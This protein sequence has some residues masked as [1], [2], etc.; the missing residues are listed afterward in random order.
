MG[1]NYKLIEVTKEVLRQHGQN[2]KKVKKLTKT[3][4]RYL[5]L[6]KLTVNDTSE[7]KRQFDFYKA[8]SELI[9]NS[10]AVGHSNE[11]PPS[12]ISTSTV[13]GVNAVQSMTRSVPSGQVLGSKI[14]TQQPKLTQSQVKALPTPEIVLKLANGVWDRDMKE[15]EQ[16]S[17]T[18]LIKVS[19]KDIL[20]IPEERPRLDQNK[21]LI[22][23]APRREE[24]RI[25]LV[26]NQIKSIFPRNNY[27]SHKTPTSK[28]PRSIKKSLNTPKLVQRKPP[29]RHVKI[30]RTQC[31]N[32]RSRSSSIP[33]K[34]RLSDEGNHQK[35]R[36]AKRLKLGYPSS[37]LKKS[38][39][40]LNEL[41]ANRKKPVSRSDHRQRRKRNYKNQNP[42]ELNED[43]PLFKTKKHTA[44]DGRAKLS[45]GG[46]EQNILPWRND[47]LV[48]RLVSPKEP[49]RNLSKHSGQRSLKEIAPESSSIPS[50][51]GAYEKLNFGETQNL[52]HSFSPRQKDRDMTAKKEILRYAV[53][54]FVHKFESNIPNS[55][56]QKMYLASLCSDEFLKSLHKLNDLL[57]VNNI[58]KVSNQ[59]NL[60]PQS[61]KKEGGF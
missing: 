21:G 31:L 18:Q 58:W 23:Q 7:I 25:P 29:K 50:I 56:H 15:Q 59:A 12:D 34:R 5:K 30:R 53:N 52:G 9:M 1:S 48:G 57:R 4:K 22:G 20:R 36:H 47:N 42:N 55:Q 14:S 43:R 11:L 28:P 51:S 13:Q 38:R 26:H 45:G 17:S 27:P 8:N 33:K 24:S 2:I 19:S 54:S 49:G 3:V 10:E 40:S 37:A 60:S 16:V 32:T 41:R 39:R 44:G 6:E 61:K 46:E 35:L